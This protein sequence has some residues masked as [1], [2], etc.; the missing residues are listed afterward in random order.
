MKKIH[1][2]NAFLFF[3]L[4]CCAFKCD[5]DFFDDEEIQVVWQLENRTQHDFSLKV[6]RHKG[7]GVK[8]VDYIDHRHDLKDVFFLDEVF[9]FREAYPEYDDDV[10]LDMDIESISIVNKWGDV[11]YHEDK[12]SETPFFFDPDNWLY[13]NEECDIVCDHNIVEYF[14]YTLVVTEHILNAYQD[15]IE[16]RR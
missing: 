3:F 1:F 12:S 6:V 16:A 7:H 14:E 15:S 5:S 10:F 13:Y 11:V 2:V 9:Y 8:D 4:V